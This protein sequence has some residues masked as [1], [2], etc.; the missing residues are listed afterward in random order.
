M[1]VSRR[2]ERHVE[3]VTW[4]RVSRNHPGIASQLATLDGLTGL[5]SSRT[6]ELTPYLVAKSET[7]ALGA[8][9][10]DRSHGIAVG[11]DVKLRLSPN[12]T[13][14]AAANPDFGQGDAF[15]VFV[16]E[17]RPFFVEGIGLYCLPLNCSAINCT[18]DGLFYTRR[19]GRSPELRSRY[20]DT[21]TPAATPIVAAAK[22]TGRTSGGLSFGALD[23]VTRSVGGVGG[24]TVEPLTLAFLSRAN[25]VT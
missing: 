4:L 12:L 5:I 19:I 22:L 21:S 15:E 17:Q 23:T 24:A 3:T 16:G 9:R 13:I 2:I 18:S 25:T 7:E 1:G 20:G 6:V 8:G 11:T 10:F 14:N